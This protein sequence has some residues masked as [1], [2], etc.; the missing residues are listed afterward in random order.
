[1]DKWLWCARFYKSRSLASEAVAGGKVHVNGER[2]K[3]SRS[4]SVGDRLAITQG[5]VAREVVVRALPERRGPAAAAQACYE[6]TAQ[7]I[8]RRERLRQSQALA[9]AMTPR[10]DARP[11]KRERRLLQRLHRRQG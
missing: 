10:P 9:A 11:D 4:L 3:P 5:A 1:M 2:V 6:E 7:S 8:E